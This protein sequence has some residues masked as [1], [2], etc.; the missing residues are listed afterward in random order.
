MFMGNSS[1]KSPIPIR[2][3]ALA[4][5]SAFTLLAAG[6]GAGTSSIT[7]NQTVGTSSGTSRPIEGTAFG[8]RQPI[9]GATILLCEAG[10]GGYGVGSCSPGTGNNVAQT[11]TLSYGTFTIPA[12]TCPTTTGLLYLEAVGGTTTTGGS[13][14][15]NAVLMAAIGPCSTTLSISVYVDEVTTVGSVFALGQFINS[16]NGTIGTS[17]TTQ[18]LTGLTNAFNTVNNLVNITTGQANSSLTMTGTGSG[19]NGTLTSSASIVM[20]PEAAK[21]NTIANI[22]SAC[23]NDVSP[24]TNVCSPLFADL[25]GSPSNTLQAALYM[26]T[27]PAVNV[28]TVYN[29]VTSNGPFQTPL[30]L[31]IAPNDWTIGVTYN[32]E[33]NTGTGTP[34][35]LGGPELLAI[36]G[37]GNVW[38]G[39]YNSTNGSLTEL[40]PIG[41]P[42]LNVLNSNNIANPDAMV[43]DPSGNV[44]VSNY[45][46]S[47]LLTASVVEYTTAGA[48]NTF[49]TG[50]GPGE[51]VSDSLGDIFVVETSATSAGGNGAA[52]LAKIPAGSPNG[53]TATSIGALT[54][55]RYSGIVM[56]Q[57]Y[58]I[59]IGGGGTGLSGTT[60]TTNVTPF[61]YSGGTWTLGTPATTACISSSEGAAI[62]ST[63]N[64]WL[65][66][67]SSTASTVCEI[68]ASS[69]GTVSGPSS[70]D[71]GGGLI[72]SGNIAVDGA[73]NLWVSNQLTTTEG[74]SE[75]TSAGTALSPVGGGFLH[76]FDEP[77]NIAVDP[78]GNV[79]VG[80]YAI[81]GS[82]TI[83]GYITEIV[84]AAVPTVTPIAAGLPDSAGGTM[85]IGT[86]P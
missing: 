58:N 45:G 34:Y 6:C 76:N 55:T 25:G 47:A 4:F 54:S 65:P 41:K 82:G 17:G 62:D 72:K 28:G 8:G 43:I 20:K 12:F 61:I 83:Y 30:P 66:N 5:V 21:I 33:S 32:S 70:G 3:L 51:M 69:T 75:F 7:G 79:W 60:G 53:T 18:G 78:S 74:V 13:N 29:L 23:V 19:T 2:G 39:N 59:W 24:Y 42:L 81:T 26:A 85:K 44:Y 71:T 14:N 1:K 10:N 40:S 16:T 73:G 35:I 48:T 52:S 67:Y 49:A 56:D 38:V 84:G 9:A 15:P 50:K 27:N 63:G 22:L 64:I 86:R 46:A 36:D 37:G 68:D 57:N 11:S 77:F 31:T 80:N